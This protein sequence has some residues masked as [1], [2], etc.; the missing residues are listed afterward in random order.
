MI[1]K[2][3]KYVETGTFYK[4]VVEDGSDLIFIV[5]YFGQILYHNPAVMVVLG[6][7]PDSLVKKNFFDYINPQSVAQFKKDFKKCT[8][9]PYSKNV[10]FQFKTS[11]GSYTYL[12]FNSINL[13]HKEGFEGFILDCRDIEQRKRDAEELLRAKEAKEKFLANM[14]H[15]IRTPINGIGGMVNLLSGTNPTAEQEKFLGAIKNSTDN[16]KV[17]IN[18]ILDL[19]AI[20]SGKLNFE[21][22]GF[23]LSNL[24]P[25]VVET[26]IPQA[27]HKRVALTYNLPKKADPILLGDPVRLS[28]VLINLISNAIKFTFSGEIGIN[29]KFKQES[30]KKVITSF[31][32]S[33]TGIGIPQDK[34]KS[35]FDTFRQADESVTRKFGGTGLGLSIVQQ[36]IDLQ[37]GQISVK[38]KENKGST[39][40]ITLPYDLGSDQDLIHD[41]GSASKTEAVD[42][43]LPGMRVLLVEDNDIN[44]LYAANLM[45]NWDCEIDQAEN[46][47]I[48]IEKLNRKDYDI[49]L[50]DIQMPVMDGFEATRSIRNNFDPPK[51]KTPIIA[52]TANA[53]R[54]DNEK[55][56]TVG[57]NK[58]LSKPFVPNELFSLMSFF[59]KGN[60]VS[61]WK[62]T[63]ESTDK[64]AVLSDKNSSSEITS[65]EY[66][67]SV[68]NN[69][70]GF[71]KEMLN[72]FI[73][74]TPGSLSEMKVALDK[75]DYQSVGRIAHKIKPSI[76]FVGIS[77]MKSLVKEVEFLGKENG[78]PEILKKKSHELIS[79]LEIAIKEL[80]KKLK[81]LK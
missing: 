38:S 36:L 51:S 80:Q 54:G 46:G 79:T 17:I 26:F 44:R 13:K 49:I 1:N 45:K 32:V 59:Y 25:Q 39:F 31:E 70:T 53:I 23:K 33:D 75:K 14:S 30:K 10:E 34:L 24:L 64:D 62:H 27:E 40:T 6:Y 4:A 8:K 71:V 66:L 78:D 81:E 56:I 74:S 57:M 20:E 69:D 43:K 48:C 72:T 15:E 63:K 22:I 58:Y 42:S 60:S 16:L 19:S 18:D 61:T 73:T 52:L 65:L 35:I 3:T 29:V 47:L 12:E 11:E 7:E 76:S 21:K 5:D 37:G 2:L 28:Q 41:K 68:S 77:S 55:C 50:M 9:L 67:K